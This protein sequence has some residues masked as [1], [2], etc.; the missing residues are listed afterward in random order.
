MM[1]KEHL[2]EVRNERGFRKAMD[3]DENWTMLTVE[4]N[5]TEDEGCYFEITKDVFFTKDGKPDAKWDVIYTGECAWS[6]GAFESH[7][8]PIWEDLIAEHQAD[9][10]F[11]DDWNDHSEECYVA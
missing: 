8:K 11:V 9:D 4:L 2:R 5:R 6:S 7:L 1:N 3:N 10:Y